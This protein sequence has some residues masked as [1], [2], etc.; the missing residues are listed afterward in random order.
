VVGGQP[1]GRAGDET[2]EARNGSAGPPD[3]ADLR[4]A[5]IERLLNENARLNERVM[6]FLKLIERG[7]TCSGAARSDSAVPDSVAPDS[8]A[9]DSAA[10][11]NAAVVR[12]LRAA[13]EAELRP[14]MLVMLRLL[15]K[16][17]GDT[18][19]EKTGRARRESVRPAAP[20]VAP[21]DADGIVDLDAQCP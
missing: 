10:P 3:I 18:A 7:Q 9:P 1:G 5:E 4:D 20:K 2:A 11:D 12:D 17:H 16:Q 19:S 21:Y 14:V 8:A 13:L 6:F 15:E